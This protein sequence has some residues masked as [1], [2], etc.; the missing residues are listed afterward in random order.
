MPESKK[1]KIKNKRTGKVTSGKTARAAMQ[2]KDSKS[3]APVEA[4][5]A[6]RDQVTQ[7]VQDPTPGDVGKSGKTE[8]KM[9]GN[10]KAPN[11]KAS[12]VDINGLADFIAYA[13][14]RKGQSL[15]S[16]SP[17]EIKAIN[18]NSKLSDENFEDLL[19]LSKE[20]ALLAVPRLIVF[21]VQAIGGPPL[22]WQETRRFIAEVLKRHP[23]YQ[24]NDLVPVIANLDDAIEPVKAIRV[25]AALSQEVLASLTGLD[26]PKSKDAEA[27]RS[28]AIYCLAVWLSDSRGQQVSR[29]IRWLYD[30]YWS[31]VATPD[32]T[33]N[34][35]LQAVTDLT[36][37]RSVGVACAQFKAEAD[38]RALRAA[39][40]QGRVDSLLS[41]KQE[42]RQVIAD[43]EAQ[44]QE[45]DNTIQNIAEALEAER[46]AHANSRA[47]LGDD[48]EHLRSNVVR[49]LKREVSLLTEGLQ[50]LR[51]DPPK[52]RV[53]DDHAERALDGLQ[54]AIK[55][56]EEEH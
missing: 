19:A 10:K 37:V 27:L 4:S 42:L 56:L 50:A 5:G 23:V 43:L 26:K 36:E 53:M 14:S 24:H 3:G 29:V 9:A 55:E 38:E 54:A 7:D 49:R 6:P 40:L 48:R 52:V 8:E 34:T 30:G 17:G 11:K 16:L 2:W 22:V 35:A 21:S 46:S 25:L 18:K 47:H 51:K 13:Y 31:V 33:Q 28:N 39:D 44:I 1:V 15:K 32:V 45:R 41:D 20:D 12:K